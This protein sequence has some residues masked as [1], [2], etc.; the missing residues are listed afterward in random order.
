MTTII[1]GAHRM[2]FAIRLGM[3]ASMILLAGCSRQ[4]LDAIHGW[5]ESFVDIRDTSLEE[6]YAPRRAAARAAFQEEIGPDFKVLGDKVFL[7]DTGM[8]GPTFKELNPI[9]FPRKDD[10]VQC[11]NAQ[12]VIESKLSGIRVKPYLIN[13]QCR[14]AVFHF[15]DGQIND[16]KQDVMTLYDVALTRAVAN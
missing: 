13:D 11:G 9:F 14:F 3:A 2:H 15:N 16:G 10:P 5:K 4:P 8:D 1:T 12:R 7:M 6:V